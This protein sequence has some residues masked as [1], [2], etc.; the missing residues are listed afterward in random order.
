MR[1]RIL[2]IPG[3]VCV[4]LGLVPGTTIPISAASL[5]AQFG[6]ALVAVAALRC[7]LAMAVERPGAIV[8][9]ALIAFAQYVAAL[10]L[11]PGPT[12]FLRHIF[13]FWSE[14]AAYCGAVLLIVLAFDRLMTWRQARGAADG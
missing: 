3:I 14:V 12:L 5:L 11:E 9:A 4:V 2:L 1:N 6:G 7:L 10:I 13:L 8:G